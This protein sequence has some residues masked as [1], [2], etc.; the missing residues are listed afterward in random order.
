MRELTKCW[1]ALAVLGLTSMPAQAEEEPLLEDPVGLIGATPTPFG[2]ATLTLAGAYQRARSGPNR[3]TWAGGLETEL[4]LL[5]G[6]D[7][8]F[9]QAV[10]WGD[11]APRPADPAQRVWGGATQIGLRWQFLEENGPWP[12]L[13][14]FGAVFTTYG[15]TSRPSEGASVT[16]L[17][18]R[19]LVDGPRPLALYLNAGVVGLLD[20][21]PGERPARYQF[22]AG[23]AHSLAQDTSIAISASLDQ[24]GRGERD[25]TLVIGGIW[26]RLGGSGPILSLAAGAG[27]GRDSPS[28]VIGAAMKWVFGGTD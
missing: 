28:F 3:D 20:P 16:G 12:A 25:E 17:L 22:A 15:E 2:G 6:A 18:T 1:L 14:V 8:R 4:G 19:T 21:Q 5:R 13:G 24:Q 23:L 7:L 27:I 10:A 9:Q 11:A 26:H